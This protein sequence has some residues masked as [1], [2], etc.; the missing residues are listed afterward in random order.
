M[1]I[2]NFQEKLLEKQI[3]K[4]SPVEKL[5][6][7]ML[8]MH[9]VECPVIH[10]FGPGIYM[11]EVHL[12]KGAI[13]VGHHHNFEHMNIFVKGRM[14]LLMDDGTA[15]EI[16]AP[17]S[18][19]AKPGRKAAY[20]HEDCIFIN[21]FSTNEKNVEKLEAH[22]LTKSENFETQ[23]IEQAKV[24]LLSSVID[25]QDYNLALSELG[26]TEETVRIT[27]ENKDDMIDLPYG[28]YKIK[29]GKSKIEGTGL[30]ATSNILPNEIITPA[31]ILGKRTIAERFTNH[32]KNPNAFIVK[33][34]NGD[35]FLVAKLKISG[36]LG[37]QDGEEITIDYRQSLNLTLS[38]GE[39][40]CQQ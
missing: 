36:C 30:F 29:T 17:M 24:L 34:E 5:E 20:I 19:V 18:F 13:I 32:S 7:K 3:E 21:V 6:Q 33:G 26:V 22:Y 39:N 23:Q 1:N 37:G 31:R 2:I 4:A 40:K 16:S 28:A 15:Q 11:R 35:T 9:Q 12:P 14:S 27:S 8:E 10:N 25:N 38:V